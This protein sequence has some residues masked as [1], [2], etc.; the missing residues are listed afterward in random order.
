ME[1]LQIDTESNQAMT[2]ETELKTEEAISDIN[3]EI[4]VNEVEDTSEAR[5][6]DVVTQ[7]DEQTKMPCDV[8][9]QGS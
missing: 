8:A 7:E 5:K 4:V 2:K 1:L 6:V 3:Q 9:F